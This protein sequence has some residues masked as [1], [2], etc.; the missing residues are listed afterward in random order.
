MDSD[1]KAEDDGGMDD[2]TGKLFRAELLA[3]QEETFE[4]HHGAYTDKGTSLF[5]TLAGIDHGLASRMLPG[6]RESTAGHVYH[7]KFYIIVLQEY[8]TGDRTGKTDWSESWRLSMVD[9]KAWAELRK[10]LEAEYRKLMGFVTA[11]ADWGN[12]DHVGG[13]LAILAHCAYHLGAIRQ[14]MAIG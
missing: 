13:A 5:E 7:A 3:I 11:K 2:T 12:G 9:E 10:D 6:L 1:R 4:K 14:L 8:M